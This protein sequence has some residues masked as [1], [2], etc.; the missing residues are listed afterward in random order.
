MQATD[1][2]QSSLDL[3]AKLLF[4]LREPAASSS[5]QAIVPVSSYRSYFK[6]WQP[7]LRP[8]EHH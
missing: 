3:E 1:D 7:N 5:E 6:A 4:D 8:D 2:L